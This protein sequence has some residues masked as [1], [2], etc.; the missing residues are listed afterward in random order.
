[1]PGSE[2][3]SLKTGRKVLAIDK[4]TILVS[5]LIAFLFWFVYVSF[6]QTQAGGYVCLFICFMF[7]EV[8]FII[9]LSCCLFI[10]CCL[11][12]SHFF[13]FFILFSLFFCFI[14]LRFMFIWAI[15][16]ISAELFCCH[17]L[18]LVSYTFCS[19]Y[20]IF[21]LYSEI[22]FY[23]N[24][25]IFSFVGKIIYLMMPGSSKIVK[26]VEKT[27]QKRPFLTREGVENFNI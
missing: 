19:F 26:K 17:F 13:L 24:S 18:L 27:T 5:L 12:C 25:K 11:N 20:F 9:V 10:V 3:L 21:K 4:Q 15:L 7:A 14:V 1:V 8:F 2:V 6:C 22:F 16:I 23:Y